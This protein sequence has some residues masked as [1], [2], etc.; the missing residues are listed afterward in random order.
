MGHLTFFILLFILIYLNCASGR[1][2][3][4][5]TNKTSRHQAR[6]QT[7]LF[8]YLFEWCIRSCSTAR[9]RDAS[10]GIR[11]LFSLRPNVLFYLICAKGA[12]PQHGVAA[13]DGAPGLFSVFYD[14]F[15]IFCLELCI[16]G[17]FTN[18][19]SQYQTGHQ[20]VFIFITTIITIIII[21][22]IIV[23]IIIIII[24]SINI[25]CN[26]ASGVA[27]Q[28]GLAAPAGGPD[29]LSLSIFIYSFII[30]YFNFASGIT[31]PQKTKSCGTRL[32]QNVAFWSAIYA[33]STLR[34]KKRYPVGL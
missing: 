28:R 5:S 27:P 17:R 4:T 6:H 16:K 26:C 18:K 1:L 9:S 14:F 20:I 24:I 8:K 10:K 30:I 7:L 32:Q 21:T 22:I 15:F 31:P 33:H 23:I 2:R 12:A 34:A 3:S 13:P 25:I 19:G 29:F 11:V